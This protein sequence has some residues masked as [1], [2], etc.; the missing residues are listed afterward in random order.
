MPAPGASYVS[1][2]ISSTVFDFSKQAAGYDQMQRMQAPVVTEARDVATTF[3]LK[4]EEAG[5]FLE[6]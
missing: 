6:A 3:L 4:P 1:F 2:H 5:D